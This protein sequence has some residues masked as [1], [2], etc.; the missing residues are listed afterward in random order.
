MKMMGSVSAA[1][2]VLLECRANEYFWV[3]LLIH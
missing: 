2:F 1:E 3:D